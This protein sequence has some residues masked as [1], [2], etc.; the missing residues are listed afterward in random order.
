MS[1]NPPEGPTD[2]Q[3]DAG[4]P[5]PTSGYESYPTGGDA[6]GGYPSAPPPPPGSFDGYGPQGFSA[7][8]AVGYGWRKF[9]ANPGSWLLIA[10]LF[11]VIQGL[12]EAVTGGLSSGGDLSNSYSSSR[13]IGSLVSAVVGWILQAQL[14]KGALSESAGRKASVAE[15]FK[16]ENVGAVIVASIIVGV[17]S[18]I[19]FLLLVIPGLIVVFLS[20]FVY[21]FLQDEDLDGVAAVKAS[22][23]LVSKNF[24]K[25]IGLALLLIVINLVGLCLVGIG[26]LVTLP[27]TAIAT[28]YAYKTLQGQPVAP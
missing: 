14:V 21:Q 28:T 27:I 9:W 6:L 19:G 8:S 3:P 10:L 26:L 20:M 25:L 5:E 24:G 18:T 13:I 2:G 23:S 17:L 15:F 7:G 16:F 22:F 1:T 12:I 4:E 11:I